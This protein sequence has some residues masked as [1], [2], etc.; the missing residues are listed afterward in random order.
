MGSDSSADYKTKLTY[1]PSAKG[2]PAALPNC[3]IYLNVVFFGL[4]DD[5]SSDT[6]E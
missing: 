2:A 5:A 3:R 6:E 4:V 1:Q